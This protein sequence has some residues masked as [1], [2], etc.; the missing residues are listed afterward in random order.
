MGTLV[1]VQDL[2]PSRADLRLLSTE[3]RSLR[4]FCG[5]S[6]GSGPGSWSG[7]W[8]SGRSWRPVPLMLSII[9][10]VSGAHS[11]W[12]EVRVC[13][14][15]SGESRAARGSITDRR[16]RARHGSLVSLG[17][18]RRFLGRPG[19]FLGRSGGQEDEYLG[20][21]RGDLRRIRRETPVGV[22]GGADDGEVQ[23]R[24]G[25]V[26]HGNQVAF[27][28]G[29]SRLLGHR[30]LV[31]QAA[32]EDPVDS[33]GSLGLLIPDPFAGI[34]SLVLSVLSPEELDGQWPSPRVARTW[35]R[36]GPDDPPRPR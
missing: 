4:Q 29:I 22:V 36:T 23:D 25:E 17:R 13:S 3:A 35:G 15:A 8:R 34:R 14:V 26:G 16:L 19:R 21:D 33:K 30:I 31:D 10:V 2:L 1:R 18:F 5:E 9:R 20:P 7:P 32:G 28:G 6:T 24:A 27:V 11:A 12:T